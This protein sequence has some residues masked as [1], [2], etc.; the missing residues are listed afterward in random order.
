MRDEQRRTEAMQ[1]E[2]DTAL[3]AC[4]EQAF[5]LFVSCWLVLLALALSVS[6]LHDALP[7]HAYAVPA[8]VVLGLL[9]RSYAGGVEPGAVM[10]F[11]LLNLFNFILINVFLALF[12]LLPIPPFD[13]S[14][15][16]HGLL[17]QA[18]AGHYER[19]APLGFPLMLLLI[20]VLPWAIPRSSGASPPSISRRPTLIRPA[21]AMRRPAMP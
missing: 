19:L 10:G 12:N 5:R 17:P 16:V 14:H 3:L 6:P 20:V 11:V 15:I 2:R 8:L 9:L 13:G 4:A 7:T 1:D 21:L 18:L